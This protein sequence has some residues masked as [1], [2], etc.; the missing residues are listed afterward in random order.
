MDITYKFVLPNE[1]IV[2]LLESLRFDVFDM[3]K[4]YLKENETFYEHSLLNGQVYAFGA[5]LGEELLGGCYVSV[6][7]NHL[8]IDQIFIKRGYQKEKI[9]G[10]LLKYVLQRKGLVEELSGVCLKGV[11]LDAYYNK[12]NFYEKLGFKETNGRMH[13][14]F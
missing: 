5:F 8:Y 7:L 4:A 12:Q 9:G 14:S 2:H 11:F 3:D 13:K 1:E 10:H 6:N